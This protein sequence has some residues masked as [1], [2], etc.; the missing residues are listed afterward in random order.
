MLA[1]Q[2]TYRD[3]SYEVTINDNE[4]LRI[5]R[6]HCKLSVIFVYHFET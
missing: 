3:Q 1:I 4:P 2:Y 6:P 5:P